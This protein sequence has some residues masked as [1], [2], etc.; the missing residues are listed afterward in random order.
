MVA[1]WSAASPR[2]FPI[3]YGLPNSGFLLRKER[4]SAEG[5]G[6][7]SQPPEECG[8]LY[9]FSPTHPQE[10]PIVF[11]WRRARSL[12]SAALLVEECERKVSGKSDVMQKA[13]SDME[14]GKMVGKVETLPQTLFR[15]KCGGSV[16][17]AYS[18]ISVPFRDFRS[19]KHTTAESF[20]TKNS[21]EPKLW[22]EGIRVIRQMGI[23]SHLPLTKQI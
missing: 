12:K 11:H 22:Y 13:M 17:S 3:S 5:D 23:F 4:K 15:P 14:T 18:V 2:Q 21:E 7:S 6:K 20:S 16:G 10:R 19:K 1:G 9:G 8:R